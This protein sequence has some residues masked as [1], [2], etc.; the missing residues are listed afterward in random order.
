[1][2]ACAAPNQFYWGSYEDSLYSR[3]QHAGAK[4]EAGAATMLL[5]TIDEAQRNNM[6]V[7]PGVHADYGYLLLKQGNADGAITELQKESALYPESKPLMETMV[8]RIQGRKDKEKVKKS[9]P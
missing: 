2:S 5:T 6:K 3:H 8:S 9:T 7:G 4:G 1:V